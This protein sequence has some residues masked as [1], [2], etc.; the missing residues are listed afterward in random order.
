MVQSEYRRTPAICPL[1]TV[2]I[3]IH[4]GHFRV[5]GQHIFPVLIVVTSIHSGHSR[6][7]GFRA[8]GVSA[9]CEARYVVHDKPSHLI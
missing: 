1:L 5:V 6:V 2:V 4:C 9:A 7:L 3:V 8:V